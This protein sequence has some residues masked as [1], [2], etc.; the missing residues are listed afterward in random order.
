MNFVFIIKCADSGAASSSLIIDI[1]E[2]RKGMQPHFAIEYNSMGGNSWLGYPYHIIFISFFS[3]SLVCL[4][5]FHNKE[6][7]CFIHG[8]QLSGMSDISVDTTWGAPVFDA[9]RYY[10]ISLL[11]LI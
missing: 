5:L 10:S 3:F 9:V 8:W 4:L 7:T 1:P 6:L 11:F 2:G